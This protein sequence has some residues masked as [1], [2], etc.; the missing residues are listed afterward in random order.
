[1]HPR[2]PRP[3]PARRTS[4]PPRCGCRCTPPPW[5]TRGPGG[6]GRPARSGARVEGARR[7]G[8]GARAAPGA[9]ARG[10]RARRRRAGGAHGARPRAACAMARFA[11]LH[12][13]GAG[14]GDVVDGAGVAPA[15]AVLRFGGTQAGSA[16][17]GAPAAARP[18][19]A[20]RRRAAAPPP[21]LRARKAAAPPHRRS[22]LATADR[23]DRRAA[24]RP[25][26]RPSP[27]ARRALGC[28]YGQVAQSWL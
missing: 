2:P 10:A 23:G 16:S 19:R 6:A 15:R 17:A 22:A 11:R 14:L 13:V 25:R 26:P 7:R 27:R 8:R 3:R 24:P 21:P 1:M 28:A 4:T 20:G 5:G 9:S 18:A 12:L